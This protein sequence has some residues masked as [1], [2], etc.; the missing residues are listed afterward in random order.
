MGKDMMP[1][2][3]W[4][5]ERCQMTINVNP[6]QWIQT[7]FSL[8]R[9]RSFKWTIMC[10]ITTNRWNLMFVQIFS[11]SPYETFSKRVYFKL[12][13]WN[14]SIKNSS[15]FLCTSIESNGTILTRSGERNY[16]SQ[17]RTILVDQKRFILSNAG[18]L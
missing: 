1:V 7:K 11:M 17:K 5:H 10:F 16:L 4:K 9:I 3:F 8:G 12:Q 13:F 6:E 2:R 15:T 14:V 18:T